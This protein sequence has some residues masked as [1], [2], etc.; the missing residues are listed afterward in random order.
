MIAYSY[1][2]FSTLKQGTGNSLE[3][4]LSRT[5]EYCQRNG[6]TLDDT[7]KLADLGVSSFRGQNIREGALAAFLELCRVGRIPRGSTLIVESLDRLSRA[8]IRTALQLFLSLLDYGVTIVT[9]EPEREYAPNE[10]DPLA[11]IEPLIVFARAHEES[12]IK[13]QRVRAAARKRGAKAQHAPVHPAA[14][15]PRWIIKRPNGS[16]ALHP[17]RSVVVRRMCDLALEGWGVR[18]IARILTEEGAPCWG[19]S[20]WDPGSI[21]SILRRGHICGLYHPAGHAPLW[22]Y[23]PAVCTREEWERICDQKKQFIGGRGGGRR[24]TTNL[25]TDLIYEARSGLRMRIRHRDPRAANGIMLATSPQAAKPTSFSYRLIEEAILAFLVELKV[26]DVAIDKDA[27]KN[28]EATRQALQDRLLEIDEQ[29]A[30]VRVRMRSAAN[31]YGTYLD[32]IAEL[33]EEKIQ[34]R[35]KLQ[36]LQPQEHGCASL[37][38]TQQLIP[39]LAELSGKELMDLRWR[40]KG[41]IRTLVERIWLYRP[42]IAGRK[43]YT[44]YYLHIQIDL[45]SGVKRHI[46]AVQQPFRGEIK[47]LP[48]GE[49]LARY[50]EDQTGTA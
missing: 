37:Q 39:L 26:E 1:V 4:Q 13:S 31:V 21:R 10:R 16:L 33:E 29:L 35:E 11:L 34:T 15:L 49:D 17:Q 19:R 45:R 38:D 44:R 41:R 28:G 46:I 3:R 5:V 23:Y 48:P 20:R 9:L 50:R 2:R 12:Y 40:I 47:P 42:D 14:H 30:A 25:F 27:R 8:E 6:I 24:T 36:T 32:L 43:R 18:S 7:L 22:D